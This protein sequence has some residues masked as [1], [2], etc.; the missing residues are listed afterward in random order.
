VDAEARANDP[1]GDERLE[2]SAEF[3]APRRRGL[4]FNAHRPRG[5]GPHEVDFAAVA[6]REALLL[7]AV[8][9]LRHAEAARICGVTAAV[10]RQRVSRGRA[11]LAD[12]LSD[13][14]VAGVA[15]WKAATT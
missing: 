10:M 14:P 13:S 4:D 3:T 1:V 7:V 6:S 11:M 2:R 9:G 12:R 5:A 8:E 15:V